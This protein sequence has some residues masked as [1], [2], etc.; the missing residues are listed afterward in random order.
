MA[1]VIGESLTLELTDKSTI[2]F[3]YGDSFEPE[4][5]SLHINGVESD[6]VYKG[7]Q[8]TLLVW[9][10]TYI[11]TK[12][13]SSRTLERIGLLILKPRSKLT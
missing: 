8:N 12:K 5:L 11:L 6:Q 1:K 3:I 4:Q 13:H 9:L 2:M 7:Y 10:V